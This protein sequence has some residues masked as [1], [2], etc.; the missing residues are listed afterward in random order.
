MKFEVKNLWKVPVYCAV[1]SWASFYITAYLGRFF[2]VV[3]EMGT[4]GIITVSADPVRSAIFNV[5]SFLLVLL[6]GVIWAFRN[7][8]KQEIIASSAIASVIYLLITVLQLTITDLP[9]SFML[10]C[11]QSWI[12]IPNSLLYALTGNLVVSA[13]ISCFSPMMFILFRVKRRKY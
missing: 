13:L 3:K 1:S 6:V 9:T 5:I 7:M 8:T 11:F 10:A 12:A 2:F 4:D